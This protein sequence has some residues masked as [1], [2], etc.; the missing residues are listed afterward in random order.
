[1]NDP[2][3]PL[4]GLSEIEQEHLYDRIAAEIYNE[5]KQREV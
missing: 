2:K 5:L 4:L 3:Q 1:M